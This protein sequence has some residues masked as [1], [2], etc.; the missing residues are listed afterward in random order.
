MSEYG[1]L[2]SRFAAA[3]SSRDAIP[4]AIPQFMG[5]AMSVENRLALYR[6]NVLAAR[7]KALTAAYPVVAQLVGDEFFEALAA[8]YMRSHPAISGDLNEY[9]SAF[10][11]FLTHFDAVAELPYLPDV[12]RLEW[13]AHRSHY[14]AD[15]EA[16]TLEQIAEIPAATQVEIR[17]ILRPTCALLRSDYP[18][19]AIWQ[20]HQP[21]YTGSMD[22]DLDSGSHFALAHRPQ[23]RVEVRALTVG[24]YFFLNSLNDDEPLGHAVEIALMQDATFDLNASLA[25]AFSDRLFA[26]WRN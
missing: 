11:D 3:L 13:Q 22:I 15:S 8:R 23:W 4:D 14:A 20:V 2:Q 24:E 17:F 25:Q 12:A 21:R 7:T 9:G 5:D 19:A 10:G 18:I 16:M 6:G 1:R 26:G